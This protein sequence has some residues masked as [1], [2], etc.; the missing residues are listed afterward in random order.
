MGKDKFNYD[1]LEPN[2]GRLRK[3]IITPGHMP[4]EGDRP[5]DP[6]YIDYKLYIEGADY[7]VAEANWGQSEGTRYSAQDGFKKEALEAVKS[8][9]VIEQ[10][11]ST[12]E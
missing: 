4:I 3:L 11:G 8:T 1:D 6:A 10:K 12:G 2:V 7:E 5:I 9:D